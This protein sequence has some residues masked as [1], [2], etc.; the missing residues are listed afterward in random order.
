MDGRNP[1]WLEV[2]HNFFSNPQRILLQ[3]RAFAEFTDNQG[4]V[5]KA[6]AWVPSVNAAQTTVIKQEISKWHSSV[7]YILILVS[8]IQLHINTNYNVEYEDG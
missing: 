7:N 1:G 8:K 5:R 4:T 2:T 3:S 6:A